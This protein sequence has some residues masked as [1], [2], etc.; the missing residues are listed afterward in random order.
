MN[1]SLPLCI[2]GFVFPPLPG[3][4]GLTQES[5]AFHQLDQDALKSQTAFSLTPS[6]S[7]QRFRPK[8]STPSNRSHVSDPAPSLS[9]QHPDFVNI[10]LSSLS[11]NLPPLPGKLRP[12]HF[13]HLLTMRAA[14]PASS[15][16]SIRLLTV[17]FPEPF[18]R[19]VSSLP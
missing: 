9:R 11:E 13:F 18:E 6:L 2:Y 3:K 4:F 14:P 17:L 10:R 5:S 19:N 16:L 12:R 1:L 15:S 7:R 8:T